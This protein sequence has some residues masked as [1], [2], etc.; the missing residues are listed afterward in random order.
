MPTVIVGLVGFVMLSRSGPFGFLGL[1]LTP[2]GI[3]VGQ[4]LLISPILLGLIISSFSGIDKAVPE[5]AI[6]L[7]A[8]RFQ[9]SLI[10]IREARYAI[11]TAVVMGFGRA[12]GEL[13]VSSIIGG[14]LAGYTRTLATAIQLETQ[15]G[16]LELALSLGFILLFIALV[17]NLALYWLQ[18]K[19]G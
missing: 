18:Y 9:T 7:G 17:V 3:I 11:V 16:D 6:A 2:G 15:R 14:N 10:T 19:R 8:N 12:M 1:F 4:V 13:G 5:T